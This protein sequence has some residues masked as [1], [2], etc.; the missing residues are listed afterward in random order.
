MTAAE[1]SLLIPNR[2]GLHARASARFT[3][4]SE[5]FESLVTVS[6]DGIEAD[7]RS[8]LDLLLLAAPQGSFIHVRA[9]GPDAEDA[10][11]ALTRLVQGGFGESD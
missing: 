3:E 9:E 6:R 7:G 4:V 10:I 2:K 11:A 1:R 5:R 8:I